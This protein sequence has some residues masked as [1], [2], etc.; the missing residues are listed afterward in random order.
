MISSNSSLVLLLRSFLNLHCWYYPLGSKGLLGVVKAASVL[1]EQGCEVAQGY[2]SSQA[3]EAPCEGR[4]LFC[5]SLVVRWGAGR[6]E[7]EGGSRKSW[8]RW[9][10]RT[11]SNPR[12][13]SRAAI[14]HVSTFDFIHPPLLWLEDSERSSRGSIHT[15]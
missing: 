2:T 14:C 15:G 13:R 6:A 9:K 1:L 5:T 10:L 12:L 3:F 4:F 8:R 7:E 11:S